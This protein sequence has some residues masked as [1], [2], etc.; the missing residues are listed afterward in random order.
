MEADPLELED[1]ADQEPEIVNELAAAY[2]T[3]FDEVGSTR[4]DNYLP[5]RI[6]IGTTYESP[7][8][9]TR[10]DWRHI[11]GR[12]WGR[13]SNG[14]WELNVVTP[15]DYDIDLRFPAT[16]ANGTATLSLNEAAYR[17]ELTAGSDSLTIQA[18]R[19]D[20]GPLRL[21]VTLEVDNVSKGPWQV[22][23]SLRLGG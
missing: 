12:P 15:G 10:Q 18:V 8:T 17:A 16:A 1:V 20:A 9:L 14:Y 2:D 23:V 3:W 19:L 13:D 4:P 22:D 21:E 7:T 11:K 6:G 5:P